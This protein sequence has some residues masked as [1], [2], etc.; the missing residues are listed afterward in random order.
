MRWYYGGGTVAFE[1]SW[2]P[3]TTLVQ[4]LVHLA[5]RARRDVEDLSVWLHRDRNIAPGWLG[6]WFLVRL[7]DSPVYA[8]LAALEVRKHLDPEARAGLA[9][10]EDKLLAELPWTVGVGVG[11][12]QGFAAALQAFR[13]EATKNPR[14]KW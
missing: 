14:V 5:P 3:A 12:P 6:D 4:L 7:E 2:V 11:R 13:R 9:R 10:E 8:A 1:P